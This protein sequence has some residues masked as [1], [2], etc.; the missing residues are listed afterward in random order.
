MSAVRQRARIAR[1]RRLQHGLASLAASNA[2]GHVKLL[3]ANEIRLKQMREGLASDVGSTSGAALASKGELAMRLE[4][5][6]EGLGN[7]IAGARAV[8]SL[9]EEAR[10]F[11]RREQDC[12]EKLETRA[13]SDAARAED[14][15][16]GANV[17]R[18][19]VNPLG[20]E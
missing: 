4:A 7:S 14:K 10:L 13:A 3:E 5:A 8:L 12:A 15:R 1:V 19:R 20:G 9:R 16:A 18:R 11:A 6:K 2:S 17:R